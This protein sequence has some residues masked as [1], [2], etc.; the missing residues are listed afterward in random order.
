MSPLERRLRYQRSRV[1]VRSWEYRQRRH[2][3]GVWFRLRRLLADAAGA[4]AIPM[5]EARKLIAEGCPGE[6]VGQELEPPKLIVFAPAERLALVPLARP[7]P[8]GLGA[9][10]LSAECIA[11]TRFETSDAGNPGA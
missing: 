11:L 3:R 9:E 5:D 7:I 8:V 10:L 1:L 6:P 4:Y 2:A